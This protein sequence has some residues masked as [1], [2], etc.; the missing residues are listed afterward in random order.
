MYAKRT[1]FSAIAVVT[2]FGLIVTSAIAADYYVDGSSGSDANGG[3]GWGDAFATIQKGIDACSGT[4]ADIVHVAA[5]TYTENIGLDDYVKLLG[6]YP[7][8]GGTRDSYT[9]ETV[10]DGGAS[11]MV[12][13]IAYSEDVTVDGFTIR[14]GYAVDGAGFRI[15]NCDR[16]PTISNNLIVDNKAWDPSNGRG[17][18]IYSGYASPIIRDNIIM[19]N[20]AATRGGGI[21][22]WR[23]WPTITN[24]LIARNETTNEY[25]GHYGG[26]G[27][28][29]E[30]INYDYSCAPEVINCTIADNKAI[31][32]NAGAG[33]YSIVSPYCEPV[34][35][36]CIIWH[37]GTRDDVY[38]VLDS[39]VSYCDISTGTWTGAGMIN[40]DPLFVPISERPFEYYLAHI[41][42]Q[43]GDSPCLDAGLG[44]V[45]DYGMVGTTTCTDGSPDGDDDGS[46]RT[47]PIDMGYHYP[48][49]YGGDDG[50]WIRLVSFTANA[51][52]DKIVLHWETGAEID[53]A[54]F[55]IFRTIGRSRDYERI[56]R[57]IPAEGSSTTGASYRFIDENVRPGVIYRYWLVD[58]DTVGEW[59]AHGPVRARLP[60]DLG[61]IELPTANCQLLTKDAR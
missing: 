30:A 50:T 10:I 60:L 4:T 20:V 19:D 17:G 6:G 12:V 40:Q 27:I 11:G 35:L 5:A 21:Y 8:G 16:G 51:R 24:C 3:T 1:L 31:E 44:D 42:P 7:P 59:T 41:G 53:N 61:S 45:A 47:G 18:G 37:N 32:G 52:D 9:Y 48:K 43:A 49:G 14:N 29:F 36:N 55:A 26:A 57:L 54:G 2:I 58:I 22:S 23:S 46:D 34:L 25:S 15:Y 39:D 13:D 56:S 38:G 28:Y 33:V